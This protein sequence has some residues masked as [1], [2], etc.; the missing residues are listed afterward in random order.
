VDTN[1]E[2]IAAA[3]LEGLSVVPGS[4]ISH[5]MM[6]ETDLS[7]LGKFLALT[8][9]D[10]VNALAAMQYQRAFSRTDVFQL[11]PDP[12]SSAREEKVSRELQGR[13]LFSPTATYAELMRRVE[14]GWVI[15]K[16]AL[17]AGFGFGEFVRMQTAE[18]G[19]P[20]FV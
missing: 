13:V 9:N 8:P 6:E 2:N 16:T 11:A 5:F 19:I 17:T 20:L 12:R 1:L 18:G 14:E 4:V 10:E 15:R 3:R 7:G